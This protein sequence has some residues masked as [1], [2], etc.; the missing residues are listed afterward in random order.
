[1]LQSFDTKILLV[2]PSACHEENTVRWL[3]SDDIRKT[4]GITTKVT[5]HS[6]LN[7]VRDNP[8]VIRKSII[9]SD[10]HVG[11]LLFH[12]NYNH[13]SGVLELY[14]GEPSA[15]GCGVGYQVMCMALQE[16]FD[17]LNF[18]RVSLCTRVDNYAAASLY[19]K[20]GFIQEGI[21][22]ECVLTSS[23]EFI[24]QVRWSLLS[25]EWRKT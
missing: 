1:M 21:E 5:H 9:Y 11:N 16:I 19:Q 13:R 18:H 4:F 20:L 10:V 12:P 8:K 3:N 15:R 6:H 24:D 17:Q 25:R 2:S 7:W 14:I 22:R 23:S